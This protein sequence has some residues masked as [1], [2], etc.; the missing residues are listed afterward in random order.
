MTTHPPS[1]SEPAELSERILKAWHRIGFGVPPDA[2]HTLMSACR[3]TGNGQFRSLSD[4]VEA[5]FAAGGNSHRISVH[6]PEPLLSNGLS[7]RIRLRDWGS[8]RYL[9]CGYTCDRLFRHIKVKNP[10]QSRW[11]DITIG[12]GDIGF[13]LQNNWEHPAAARIGDIRIDVRGEPLADGAKVDIQSLTCW[14]EESEILLRPGT[15][16]R[17]ALLPQ[18]TA[19]P[20]GV[21]DA[22][23]SYLK[24]IFP[25]AE[26]QA[27]AF[28]ATGRCPLIS[29]VLLPWSPDMA[30][31]AE[32]AEANTHAYSWH[33]LHPAAILLLH[34]RETGR[35]APVFAAREVVAHWLER[36]YYT[37]ESDL[38]YG[39]YPHGVAD[40]MWGL[41]LIWAEGVEREFDHR[42]MTRVGEAIVRHAQLLE[43]ELFYVSHQRTRYHNHGC[44]QDVALLAVAVAMP[45]Y[46][47]AARWRDRAC[48]R[49][50]D[51][52]ERLAVRDGGFTVSVENSIHYH[53]ILQKLAELAAAL[54]RLGGLPPGTGDMAGE[55]SAFAHLLRY[56]DGSL[57]AQGDSYWRPTG[58]F[59]PAPLTPAA[60]PPAFVV[61]PKAGYG[62][63]RGENA[64]IPSLVCLF[65]TSLSETHKHADHLSFTLFFDGI[66]WR[67]DPS[68]YSHEYQQ[69][70]PA[71]LRS[72]AAHNAIFLPGLPYS[73]APDTAH[74]QGHCEAG[75]FRFEGFHTSYAGVRV[76]RI[77]EGTLDAL[78]LR[79]TDAVWAADD[80]AEAFLMLHCGAGVVA[81][82]SG[83][84]V[85]LSHPRSRFSLAVSLPSEQIEITTGEESPARIR[86]ISGTTFRQK[87]AI[88]TIA[89]RVPIG[90]PLHWTIRAACP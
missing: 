88:S 81:R 31:P 35:D 21:L 41:L 52:M 59:A 33:A 39:W 66:E 40:R 73:I 60:P 20:D 61:L 5:C 47:S 30:V 3:L 32:V 65:A 43:S 57:P 17:P 53:Q 64:G 4:R 89:C 13:G 9:A 44:F 16:T 90:Q 56:P 71:Y 62:V 24:K 74:L 70:L 27:R 63:A 46:P 72:A 77:V 76:T 37:P 28:M 29:D 54:K 15:C 80:C 7:V 83:A 36:S 11:F 68:Y 19:P 26:D 84:E 55:L 34:A 42:F 8:R 10:V 48:E 75:T 85:V 50:A 25:G 6:I 82:Q 14:E 1:S 51:Q 79:F 18:G 23:Y 87:I 38:K 69:P 58:S 49:M 86:G 67:I 78:A 12:H 2:R 45:D 22:I